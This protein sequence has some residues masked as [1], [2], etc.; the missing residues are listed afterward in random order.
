MSS[1]VA[2]GAVTAT[3][4]SP[5]WVVKTRFQTHSAPRPIHGVEAS[6]YRGVTPSIIAIARREGPRALYKG[7]GVSMIGLVHVAI[8]FP[9]YER[10]KVALSDAS[11]HL[12]V[13]SLIVASASS[14]TVA[15]SISYPHEIVRSRQQHSTERLRATDT[16]RHVWQS[17]GWRGFYHGMGTNLLRVVPSCIITFVTYELVVRT[18]TNMAKTIDLE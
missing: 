1:A 6:Q 5:L 14:K 13:W 12:S 10:L 9:L 8:Q 11:G 7:L 16:A 3:V 17:N 18:V 4:T 15:A 2:A